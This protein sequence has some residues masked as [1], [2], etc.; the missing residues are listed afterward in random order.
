MSQCSF[1]SGPPET[2]VGA[3]SLDRRPHQAPLGRTVLSLRPSFS[4]CS[5]ATLNDDSVCA[6]PYVKRL[7][8]QIVWF[9]SVSTSGRIVV[10]SHHSHLQKKDCAASRSHCDEYRI[11][12]LLLGDSKCSRGLIP[13]HHL[14][15]PVTT[16]R[17][18][19][20][21]YGRFQRCF[22]DQASFGTTRRA[23]CHRNKPEQ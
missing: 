19:E 21:Q 6:H 13:S 8:S 5:L 11:F 1:F 10:G 20:T 7:Q 15:A 2:W 3:L 16:A 23:Y 4:G 22:T 17:S 18:R 9:Y 14:S 12:I